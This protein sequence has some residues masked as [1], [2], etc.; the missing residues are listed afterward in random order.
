MTLTAIQALPYCLPLKVPFKTAKGPIHERQGWIIRLHT[1]GGL[2]GQGE[3]APLPGWSVDLGAG[4]A[5]LLPGFLDQLDLAALSGDSAHLS[6]VLDELT[7]AR[8]ALR[9]AL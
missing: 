8:P 4:C 2:V 6:R 1:D 3:C 5:S 7:P 9:F